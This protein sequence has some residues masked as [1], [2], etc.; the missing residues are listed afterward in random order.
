MKWIPMSINFLSGDVPCL[1][2]SSVS[3]KPDD[4]SCLRGFRESLKNVRKLRLNIRS[5]DRNAEE[6]LNYLLG[7]MPNVTSL[8]V[9]GLPPRLLEHGHILTKLDLRQTAFPPDDLIEILRRNAGTLLELIVP[10]VFETNHLVI[11]AIASCSKLRN[12]HMRYHDFGDDYLALLV[13][14]APNLTS[15]DL[16]CCDRLTD[17]GV[18]H[19]RAIKRLRSLRLSFCRKL[20]T[21]ALRNL[22]AI[23][24]LQHL[25]LTY[26]RIWRKG[27]QSLAC[28]SDLRTLLLTTK[29]DSES[30]NLIV[31]NFRRLEVLDVG[32]C[33]RLTDT[34]GVKFRLLTCL[35]ELRFNNGVKFTDLTFA[36]GLGSPAM[37]SLGIE[38]SRL[39]DAGLASLA[40]HHRRLKALELQEC[41]SVTDDGLRAFVQQQ[42]FLGVLRL[43]R[44]RLSKRT[45]DDF[46]NSCPRL[47]LVNDRF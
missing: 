44:S 17:M 27:L 23:R 25:D 41:N 9:R 31:D 39:T 8:V 43:N 33:S 47:T 14:N 32:D 10:L 16:G 21:D 46:K 6:N 26:T 18:T 1:R 5:N 11:E 19:I 34:E 7:V 22:G 12:F 42:P 13:R 36:Q 38:R 29:M 35:K 28:L 4:R 45:H 20:T 24:S 2:A 37:E 30:F 3:L 15:L 40:V